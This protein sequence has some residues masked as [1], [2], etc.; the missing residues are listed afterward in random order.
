[1]K[2]GFAIDRTVPG[3]TTDT[4]LTPLS[5]IQS[6]GEFDMDP[7]AFPGHLTAKTLLTQPTHDGLQEPWAGR[8]W[9]NPPYSDVRP[10]LEK[11]SSHPDGGVA[12]L[13]AR[14]DVAWFHDVATKADSIFFPR[15]RIKFLRSN[16]LIGS[17]SAGA[18]S[19][20]LSFKERTPWA[21]LS[22]PGWIAK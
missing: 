21:S 1:M 5:I 7:C 12:L 6:L 19:M 9:L 3:V 11:L 10:W 22:M 2:K 14:T 20:F 4:W 18:P 15:G 8:V 13:F 17:N 16:G